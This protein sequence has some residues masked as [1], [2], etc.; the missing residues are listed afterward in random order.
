MSNGSEEE[1]LQTWLSLCPPPPTEGPASANLSLQESP[2]SSD[3]KEIL[4]E[5]VKVGGDRNLK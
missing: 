3:D 4:Q 2:S 1:I 5:I